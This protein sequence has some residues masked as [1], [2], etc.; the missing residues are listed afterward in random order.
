MAGKANVFLPFVLGDYA[1]HLN[2]M[3]LLKGRAFLFLINCLQLNTSQSNVYQLKSRYRFE[4]RLRNL[5]I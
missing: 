1:C 5:S 4:K 2:L 3:T